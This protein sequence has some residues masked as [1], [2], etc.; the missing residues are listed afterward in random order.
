M[1]DVDALLDSFVTHSGPRCKVADL[2]GAARDVFERGM[3]RADLPESAITRAMQS[4][5]AQ[6]SR[7]TV[8]RHRAG[9]CQTCRKT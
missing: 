1:M 3:E 5:G 9:E 8:Q 7:A 4:L 6:I 2:T